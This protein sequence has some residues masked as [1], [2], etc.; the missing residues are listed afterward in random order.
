MVPVLSEQMTE[1][2]PSDS[3]AEMSRTI[4]FCEAIAMTPVNNIIVV[5]SGML[6]GIKLNPFLMAVTSA[7]CITSHGGIVNN[8]ILFTAS[9]V[10]L[11][12]Q[13]WIR[14]FVTRRAITPIVMY[15]AN[16]L[17][18][19][20]SGMSEVVSWA[21]LAEICPISVSAPIATTTILQR[22]VATN[23]PKNTALSRSWIANSLVLSRNS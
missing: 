16:W 13:N 19:L 14:K 10:I 23:V 3:T 21:I 4:T 9:H 20:R 17:I 15:F 6:I 5:K 11:I 8:Q 12:N 22:P 7:L 18:F 1:T 2:R